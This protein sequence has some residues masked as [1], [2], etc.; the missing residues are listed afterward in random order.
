M[1]S[2]IV[3]RSDTTSSPHTFPI[4]QLDFELT[5]RQ[6]SP[7][8]SL[9]LYPDLFLGEFRTVAQLRVELE[10]MPADDDERT[11]RSWEL[12]LAERQK[13]V[14]GRDAFFRVVAIPKDCL[15]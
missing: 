4:E 15:Q 2:Q 13:A 10:A 11:W 9:A 5:R 6:C 7:P 14:T 12:A 8:T 1:S 3:A